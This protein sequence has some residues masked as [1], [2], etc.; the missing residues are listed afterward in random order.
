MKVLWTIY[1]KE[2]SKICVLATVQSYTS[3]KQKNLY[4]VKSHLHLVN[5]FKE[6]L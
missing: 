2:C 3:L 1:Y 5:A 6:F 4:K